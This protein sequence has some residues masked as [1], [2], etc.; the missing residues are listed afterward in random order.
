M[1]NVGD[2]SIMI[3]QAIFY[4]IDPNWKPLH[5]IGMCSAAAIICLVMLLPESP[6]FLYANR[7]FDEARKNLKKIAV[8]NG[9]ARGVVE[10]DSIT[11]DSEDIGKESEAGNPETINA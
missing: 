5:Q 1:I 3:Y 9:S 11:F 4:S 7:R 2:S 6:K 10:I 8:Y